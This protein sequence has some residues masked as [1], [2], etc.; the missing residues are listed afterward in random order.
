M[1]RSFGL[2]GIHNCAW[3]VDPY[4]PHYAQVPN[5]GY[6]DMGLSSDLAKAKAAFPD[7]RRAVMYTPMDLDA[8]SSREIRCD[9]E[10][11]ARELG[12][13]DVV[14]ADIERGTADGRVVE[15]VEQ[16]RRISQISER[17]D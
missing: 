5:V 11:I 6:V 16:C 2:M 1:A 12:P 10:R 17:Q 13:C 9:L 3:N 4:V 14:F 8:K 15:V 7:A